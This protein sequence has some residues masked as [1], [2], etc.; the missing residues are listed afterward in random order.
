MLINVIGGPKEIT[1][2]VEGGDT[3]EDVKE[4]IFKKLRENNLIAI[5]AN[6]KNMELSYGGKRLKNEDTIQSLKMDPEDYVTVNRTYF[7]A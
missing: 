6:K 2:E 4:K 7:A 5:N 3:I 1:I